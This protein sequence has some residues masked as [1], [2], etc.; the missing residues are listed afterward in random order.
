MVGR[1][2]SIYIPGVTFIAPDFGPCLICGHPT[3]DC[4]GED[5]IIAFT[6]EESDEV[7]VKEDIIERRWVT[8]NHLGKVLVVA[9][10]THISRSEAEKLGLI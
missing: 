7:L 2:D 5:H 10:G 4:T 3:G 1:S 8:P 9:A 6:E